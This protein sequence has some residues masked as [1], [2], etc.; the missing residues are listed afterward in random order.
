MLY[1]EVIASEVETKLEVEADV[2][3]KPRH[4]M[5]DRGVRKREHHQ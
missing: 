5:E 1:F 2:E 4:D 3:Y